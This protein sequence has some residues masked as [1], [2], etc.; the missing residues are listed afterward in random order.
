MVGLRYF[1]GLPYDFAASGHCND[2]IQ[3]PKGFFGSHSQPV[4]L[5]LHVILV[6]FVEMALAFNGFQK[7]FR[8]FTPYIGSL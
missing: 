8:T 7:H 5:H 2:E 6:V 4:A 1:S 3:S